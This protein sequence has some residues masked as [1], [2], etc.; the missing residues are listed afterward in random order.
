MEIWFEFIVLNVKNA[1]ALILT[2]GHLNTYFDTLETPFEQKNK[3]KKTKIEKPNKVQ[4]VDLN[5]FNQQLKYEKFEYFM[6][7]FQK[8]I[9]RSEWQ[10]LYWNG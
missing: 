2:G 6:G 5:F 7:I 8:F 9:H 10:L 3:T 4:E 1:A